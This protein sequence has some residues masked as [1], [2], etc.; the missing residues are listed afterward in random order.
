[1]TK[2]E[3]PRDRPYVRQIFV[4]HEDLKRLKEILANIPREDVLQSVQNGGGRYSVFVRVKKEEL[5]VIKLSIET[6][7]TKKIRKRK[8]TKLKFGI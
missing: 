4:K 7:G 2:N 6:I 1:M 3:Q 5:L 8:P